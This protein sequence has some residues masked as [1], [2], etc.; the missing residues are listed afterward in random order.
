MKKQ[1]IL[2]ESELVI[3]GGVEN[4]LQNL[5]DYLS[6]KEKGTKYAVTVAACPR[7]KQDFQAA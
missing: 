4:M 7:N 3:N 5:A 6:K 1:K 2:I